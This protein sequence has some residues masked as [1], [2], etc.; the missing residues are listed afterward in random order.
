MGIFAALKIVDT[1]FRHETEIHFGPI[2]MCEWNVCKMCVNDNVVPF[3]VSTRTYSRQHTE[4]FT[5]VFH[6]IGLAKAQ[7]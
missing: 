5:R 2:E 3:T 1:E 4:T 7:Q 6:S